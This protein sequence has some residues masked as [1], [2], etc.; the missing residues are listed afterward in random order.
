MESIETPWVGKVV[1][2]L[3]QHRGGCV[4][5]M[6]YSSYSGLNYFDLV[7]KFEGLSAVLVKKFKQIRNYGRQYC[8]GFSFGSRLCIDAGIGV[9]GQKI[10]RMD[11]CDPAGPGFNGNK[12]AKEPQLAAKNVAC[13]NTSTD[14]GTK[15]Y[16]CHQNFLMGKCGNSQPAAG[17][18]PLG[19]HGLCPYMFANAFNYK[20][21][22]NNYFNCKSNRLAN[23][24]NQDIRMGYLANFT[25][26]LVQGDIFIATAKYQ[27]YLV[28]NNVI[29]NKPILSNFP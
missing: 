17:P 22:P 24:K 21:T 27:P 2:G 10:G 15:K 7:D 4:F 16:N 20:F 5:L 9:G 23:I 8:F 3:I 14:K 11:V 6:D 19:S 1:D 12:R 29:E 25:T 18:K 28:V 26:K 13:I